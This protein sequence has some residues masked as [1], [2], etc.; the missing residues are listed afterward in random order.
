MRL[1][2]RN[3]VTISTL[4]IAQLRR[5]RQ[6]QERKTEELRRFKER[7][8][9]QRTSSKRRKMMEV[10]DSSIALPSQELRN[11]VEV[12]V[13]AVVCESELIRK[14]LILLERRVRRTSGT[15]TVGDVGEVDAVGEEVAATGS[16]TAEVAAVEA[17]RT[18]E[19]GTRIEVKGTKVTKVVVGVSIVGAAGVVGT[20]SSGREE[21]VEVVAM[22]E[23]SS[24]PLVTHLLTK[25]GVSNISSGSLRLS[26]R[27]NCELDRGPL[28]LQFKL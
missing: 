11:K 25:Q 3:W 5:Q 14:I 21:G 22:V 2:R 1:F 20:T 27:Q 8:H 9:L 26:L 7:G 24:G 6:L 17:I 4:I 19:K 16:S 23:A 10:P 18:E 15:R 12:G 13:G 28:T